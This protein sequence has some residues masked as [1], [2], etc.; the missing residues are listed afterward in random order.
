MNAGHRLLCGEA[1]PRRLLEQDRSEWRGSK[2]IDQ[3]HCIARAPGPEALTMRSASGVSSD[4][5]GSTITD[6]IPTSVTL[7]PDGVAPGSVHTW[8]T[9]MVWAP[10]STTSVVTPDTC[11]RIPVV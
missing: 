8:P 3:R 9:L 11:P 2:P 5:H 1:R 4:R 10:A 6:E 7:P